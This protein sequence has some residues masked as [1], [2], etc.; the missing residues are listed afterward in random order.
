MSVRATT[1]SK[2]ASSTSVRA[3]ALHGRAVPRSTRVYQ[4]APGLF[5]FPAFCST[6]GSAFGRTRTCDLLIRSQI[7]EVIGMRKTRISK[8]ISVR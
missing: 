8:R 6:F 7:R 4:F 3:S 5:Y 2:N 1:R